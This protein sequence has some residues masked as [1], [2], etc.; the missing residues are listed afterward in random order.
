M[1]K[2]ITLLLCLIV[3]D[4]YQGKHYSDSGNIEDDYEMNNVKINTGNIDYKTMRNQYI[5]SYTNIIKTD[6]MV[7]RLKDTLNVA[8]QYYCLFDSTVHIND[9][10][11]WEDNTEEFITHNFEAILRIYGN[12]KDDILVKLSKS[13]FVNILNEELLL[14]GV[15]MYPTYRGYDKINDRL[16]FGF[17]VSIPITDI[18]ISC[19]CSVDPE[20]G[21][22]IVME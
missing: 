7:Y 22:I 4:C 3:S 18:G 15:L 2:Y 17:S 16:G 20:T 5:L 21:E 14:H 1:M 6:T 10:Y 9:E 19:Y 13:T 12:K 8:F 11:I